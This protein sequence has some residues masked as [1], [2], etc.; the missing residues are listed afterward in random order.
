ML[1]RALLGLGENAGQAHRTLGAGLEDGRPQLLPIEF[2][3]PSV[4]LGHVERHVLDVFVGRVAPPALQALAAPPDE[5]AV[6]SDPRIDDTILRVAAERT[7][8]RVPPVM[9]GA[10]D[11]AGSGW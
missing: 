5:L 10:R 11:R 7:L 3:A 4:L 1:D 9:T 6:P 2:F 8:H